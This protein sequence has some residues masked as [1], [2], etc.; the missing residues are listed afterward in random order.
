[1]T[2]HQGGRL[3]RGMCSYPGL[4]STKEVREPAGGLVSGS[5]DRAVETPAAPDAGGLFK[6]GLST[7]PAATAAQRLGEE[8]PDLVIPQGSVVRPANSSCLPWDPGRD[9]QSSAVGTQKPS[10]CPG[11]K[12]DSKPVAPVSIQEEASLKQEVHKVGERTRRL[13]E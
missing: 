11:L 8:G 7:L 13:A 12:G 1:M 6:Q 5:G 4:Q 3:C 9:L 2:G 10:C